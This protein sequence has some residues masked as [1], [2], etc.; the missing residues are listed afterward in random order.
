M[1]I[2]TI[3]GGEIP[4]SPPLSKG[5]IGRGKESK[6]RSLLGRVGGK[7]N[8][9]GGASEEKGLLTHLLTNAIMTKKEYSKGFTGLKS[10]VMLNVRP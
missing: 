6:R 3:R 4:L 2:D 8:L 10:G 1:G 7:K 9:G 5:E